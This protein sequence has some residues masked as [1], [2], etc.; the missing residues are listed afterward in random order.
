[1]L[2]RL[3]VAP[4]LKDRYAA[5]SSELKSPVAPRPHVRLRRASGENNPVERGV[6]FESVMGSGGKAQR[7]S[8]TFIFIV[9][10]KVRRPKPLYH[11]PLQRN[12]H[13]VP[14]VV[15][16]CNLL[17]TKELQNPLTLILRDR[18]FNQTKFRTKSGPFSA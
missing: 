9:R 4:T 7:P 8:L 13:C 6:L 14:A 3:P 11:A 5:P 15:F 1:M 17:R 18:D 10:G 16:I 2:L 12:A